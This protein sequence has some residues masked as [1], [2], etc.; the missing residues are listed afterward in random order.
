MIV[1]FRLVFFIYLID[2]HNYGNL[3]TLIGFTFKKA[4]IIVMSSTIPYSVCHL[5]TASLIKK[6]HAESASLVL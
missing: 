3:S 2:N 4:I 1:G 5:S 6:V